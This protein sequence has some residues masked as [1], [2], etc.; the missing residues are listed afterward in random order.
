MFHSFENLRRNPPLP[1]DIRRPGSHC[2]ARIQESRTH[3]AARAQ[4]AASRILSGMANVAGAVV[5]QWVAEPSLSLPAGPTSVT[6]DEAPGEDRWPSA[7]HP[8]AGFWAV[9]PERS[10]REG[11]S[12]GKMCLL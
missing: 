6:E 2:S 9:G 5:A 11:C 12:L 3:G 4:P 8:S 1:A 10:G 7:K